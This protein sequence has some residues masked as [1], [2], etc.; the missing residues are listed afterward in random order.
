MHT[1]A[2][3]IVG[4]ALIGG[5]AGKCPISGKPAKEDVSLEVNGKKV[6]FCCEGCIKEYEKKIGL[7][8]EGPKNCP[9]SKKEAKAETRLIVEKAEVV[10][11]CCDGCLGK[12]LAK[13]KLK[14]EDKGAKTCAACDKPAK[15]DVALDVNGAQTYFCCDDCRKGYLKRISA[16]DKGPGKCPVSG[17][18][19]DPK[20]SLVRVKAEAVYFCC[21]NC[22][23]GYLEKVLAEAKK[24]PEKG[25]E[26]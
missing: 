22:R 10:R 2:T 16:V 3:L 13:E 4:L 21:G 26:G 17:K 20:V 8:D 25:K 15:A 5:D 1:V 19:A 6:N 23:K 11:F 24:G 7:V 9:V 12:Y 14:A 18:D